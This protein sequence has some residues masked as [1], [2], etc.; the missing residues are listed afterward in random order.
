[1]LTDLILLNNMFCVMKYYVSIT[2]CESLC[3][4]SRTLCVYLNKYNN[5]HS[6]SVSFL[7]VF[8]F[9]IY[10]IA[11]VFCN[12]VHMLVCI[13]VPLFVCMFATLCVCIFVS[14]ICVSLFICLYLCP[15]FCI[16]VCLYLCLCALLFFR[17]LRKTKRGKKLFV[18]LFDIN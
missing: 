11:F 5:L 7:F 16:F 15:F 18:C 14:L 9:I 6:L 17:S 4:W 13:F 12:F 8:Y 10:F 3:P 1:M 2:N